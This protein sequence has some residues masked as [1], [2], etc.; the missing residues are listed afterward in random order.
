[1]QKTQTA[2]STASQQSTR[3]AV[4]ETPPLMPPANILE[5]AHGVTLL[6]EMPGVSK[7]SLQLHCDNQS[8]V[9][10]GDIEIDMPQE[11]DSLYADLQTRRYRREFS[12][13]GE[14]LDT[15]SISAAL[16]NGML[17]VEIPKRSELRPR[18][19][20]VRTG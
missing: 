14:Q 17:K 5:D 20:E 1:M 10:T 13:S 3:E 6:V 16:D 2:E 15:E 18:K 4:R 12:L 9:V 8:L 19:I 7:D 11:M